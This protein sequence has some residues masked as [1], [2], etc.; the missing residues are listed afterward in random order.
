MKNL[1]LSFFLLTIIFSS[2]VQAQEKNKEPLEKSGDSYIPNEFNRMKTSPPKGL[3]KIKN[4]SSSSSSIT[5]YQVNVNNAGLNIVGD[6][7]NEPSIAI[8]PINPIQSNPINQ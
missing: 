6:A 3:F 2:N 5:T 8:N 4:R 7:A 1:I